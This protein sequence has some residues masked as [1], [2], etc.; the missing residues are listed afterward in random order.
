M[1][2]W[3]ALCRMAKSD[4]PSTPCALASLCKQKILLLSWQDIVELPWTN[5]PIHVIIYH[6]L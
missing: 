4:K 5:A 2:N 6:I 3:S 1:A